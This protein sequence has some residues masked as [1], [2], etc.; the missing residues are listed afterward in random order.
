[1]STIKYVITDKIGIITLNN[2]PV[3]AL[4]QPLR[5]GVM[6]AIQNAQHDASKA[7][8]ILCEGRTFI[9]GADIT[10]FGKPPLAPL[11]PD[12]F[13]V[14]EESVKPV[15]A[16]IHG[17]ALG[18]GFEM[19]LA[20]HYRCALRSA[21][22]GFP[23]VKLGLLPGAGGTQRTPRLAGVEAALALMTT[24]N[25]ITASQALE[26]GLIDHIID[27]DLYEGAK[28]YA[29]ALI[30][31]NMQVR[32]A[33][34]IS[35][36]KAS[37][38]VSTFENYR[39]KLAKT[40]RGQM[41]PQHIVTCVEASVNMPIEEGLKKE[42]ELFLECRNST[43]SAALQHMFFA[44][45][46]A[47]KI[48]GLSKDT[49]IKEIKA[50]AIIGG[51]TMGCGI[52][53]CFANV[54]IPIMLLEVN[55]EALQH[56]KDIITKN[57]SLTVK[58]GKMSEKTALERQAL[59]Q[60][61]TNYNDLKKVDIVI[62]AVFENLEIKKNVFE[63]LDTICEP[64]TILATNTSYLDVNVIAEATKRPQ[65]VIGLHFFSPANVMKLLEIVR[66]E[67]TS[68]EVLATSMALAKKIR[69]TPVLAK[70]CYGF[71]G[72]RM[73]RHYFRE[74]QMC[75]IEG[76]KPEQIDNAMENFG[77]AMGP[78]AVNDLAGL[79]IGYK[80]RQALSVEEKGDPRSYRIPDILVEMG[81]L[82]QKSGAGWYKYDPESRKRIPDPTIL[83]IIH[84]EAEVF[85][86]SLRQ[87]TDEEIV[88]RL[89]FA[90]INEGMKILEEGIAQRPSDIDVVYVFGYGFPA[91]RGG[92][93][94][95][96]DTIGLGKV[97][98]CICN[99]RKDYDEKYWQPSV[100]L[101]HLVRENKSLSQWAAEQS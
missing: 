54:G 59:I 87:I 42:R 34:D 71:I 41:A 94:H 36:N 2:P 30:E 35:I 52:A 90:L 100:L 33:R 58:K 92:P 40:F 76:A 4:S 61:T 62:E 86:I 69:K 10:E 46:Q 77:M 74:V 29:N 13:A 88:N 38:S 14:I 15:I 5:L 82:G 53:M 16:A 95:Y 63:K 6:Q 22:V 97:Y 39:S 7:I 93:M 37:V 11:L 50:A 89:L 28:A 85:G 19:A 25:S 24:G 72:N 20:C 83:E 47:G 75:L 21:E 32:R 57:Y 98:E 18:G 66:A 68:D 84:K 9:A 23:E 99:F 45:R 81:R 79:D 12:V 78:L 8:I 51:G 48:K 31:K 44:E 55:E 70:V 67:R 91:Y 60:G 3:N 64:G 43:Q 27:S 101:E 96:A 65:D 80:A 73:L 26:L 17:T 56:G 1:M 49:P